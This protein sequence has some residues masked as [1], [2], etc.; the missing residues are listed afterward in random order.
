MTH[1][2]RLAALAAGLILIPSATAQST[3]TWDNSSNSFKWNTNNNG[4]PNSGKNWTVNSA[5][6]TVW[7]NGNDATFLSTQAGVVGTIDVTE[8]VTA[9][10]VSF[11]SNGYT[12]TSIGG[13]G[14]VTAATFNVQP[15]ITATINC[16]TSGL[17]GTTKSGTGTLVLGN[18]MNAFGSLNVSAG[19]LAVAATNALQFTPA[20]A[21][22]GSATFSS[23]IATGF[24]TA[25]GNLSVSGTP[26][27]ALGTGSH[28]L[29]FGS[30]TANVGF[31]SLTITGWQ[32]TAGSTGTAGHLLFSDPSGLAG[33][34]SKITFAGY[35][36]GAEV[37]PSGELVPAPVPEPVGVFG[38]AAVGLGFA[39]RRRRVVRA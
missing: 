8:I 28:T 39:R 19:T 10:T 6:G 23:G 21:V 37:L 32:G 16:Q 36:N 15:G 7:A 24:S 5:T 35:G 26:T 31:T 14:R 22:N 11:F 2:T 4:S 1:R 13:S 25:A 17:T 9:G 38:L 33:S 12:L 27:I 30:F 34:L 18:T 3:Y 20:V 29:T